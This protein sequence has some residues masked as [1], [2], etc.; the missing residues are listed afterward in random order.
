MTKKINIKELEDRI[1][2][3]EGQ[4]KRAVADYRN[5]EKRV[6][7]D[8]LMVAEYIRGE[9]V[10]KILPVL[11]SLDQAVAGAAESEASTWLIGVLMSVQ[12][13]RQVLSEEGLVEIETS[14]SFDPHF[15]EAVEVRVGKNDKILEVIQRGYTLNAK[16]LRP[17]KVVVGKVSDQRTSEDEKGESNL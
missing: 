14:G 13:L 17:A 1:A 3:L 9:L 12:E 7:E 5:L 11:D 6:A 2:S 10:R 8:G 16:V 4:L 15:H